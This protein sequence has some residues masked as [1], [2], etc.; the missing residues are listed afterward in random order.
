ML[1]T[2]ITD[3]LTILKGVAVPIAKGNRKVTIAKGSK[4]FQKVPIAKGR[5]IE[6]L[7][8]F[9]QGWSSKV[10]KEK[11]TRNGKKK[12]DKEK[13]KRNGKQKRDKEKGK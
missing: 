2:L 11:G 6:R 10:E 13:G 12:R 4:R 8:H 9:L 3:C 1:N 5:Q 7:I